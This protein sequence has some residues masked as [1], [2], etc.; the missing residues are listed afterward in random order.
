MIQKHYTSFIASIIK[1]HRTKN[2]NSD[3]FIFFES[4]WNCEKKIDKS[5]KN[6]SLLKKKLMN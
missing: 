5:I 3:K 1:K 6:H 4:I 2:S